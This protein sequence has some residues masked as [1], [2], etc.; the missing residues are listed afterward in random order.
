MSIQ[1]FASSAKTFHGVAEIRLISKRKLYVVHTAQNLGFTQIKQENVGL[2]LHM[3]PI[4]HR[5]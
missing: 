4:N 5:S 1:L 2:I 3:N